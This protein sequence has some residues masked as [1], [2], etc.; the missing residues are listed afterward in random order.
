[1]VQDYRLVQKYQVLVGLVFC[2][3]MFLLTFYLSDL[4]LTDEVAH[5]LDDGEYVHTADDDPIA[6]W[7]VGLFSE[8][9]RRSRSGGSDSM[10]VNCYV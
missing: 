2:A 10:Q 6:D 1:M 7:C 3:P 9:R 5:K 8:F 4:S